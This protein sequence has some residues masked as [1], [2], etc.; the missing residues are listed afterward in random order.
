VVRRRR[1]GRPDAVSAEQT[2]PT[3][4]EPVASR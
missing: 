3:V 2:T 1:S 4:A